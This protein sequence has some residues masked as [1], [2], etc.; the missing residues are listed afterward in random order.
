MIRKRPIYQLLITFSINSPRNGRN[1]H[2]LLSKMFGEYCCATLCTAFKED[3]IF[4]WDMKHS[5]S[6]QLSV[7]DE[8]GFIFFDTDNPQMYFF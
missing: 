8:I 3:F 7:S 6:F 2:I 1:G 5:L 4:V